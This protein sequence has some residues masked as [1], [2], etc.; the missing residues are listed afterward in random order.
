MEIVNSEDEL[1]NMF[2]NMAKQTGGKRMHPSGGDEGGNEW[3][4]Q[5]AFVDKGGKATSR[6]RRGKGMDLVESFQ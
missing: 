1:M 3:E 6:K 2:I 4:E 5:M